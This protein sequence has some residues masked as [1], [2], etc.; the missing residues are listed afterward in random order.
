V[1]AIIAVL[2]AAGERSAPLLDRLGRALRRHWPLIVGALLLIAGVWA[3]V[4]GI[5]GLTG[6]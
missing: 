6:G 4:V 2:A 1:L 5:A 3:A